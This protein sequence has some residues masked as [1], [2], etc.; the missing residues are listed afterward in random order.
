[1]AK[2]DNDGGNSFMDFCWGAIIIVAFLII[3]LGL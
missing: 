3:L 1:M 2:R